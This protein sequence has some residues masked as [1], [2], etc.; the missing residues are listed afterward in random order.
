MLWAIDRNKDGPRCES[1]DGPTL[2]NQ[3]LERGILV[4]PIQADAANDGM[5][6]QSQSQDLKSWMFADDDSTDVVLGFTCQY[7]LVQ[8]AGL[9]LQGACLC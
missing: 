4:G 3:N 5:M 6:Q 8:C 7:R 9:S 2:A 1:C